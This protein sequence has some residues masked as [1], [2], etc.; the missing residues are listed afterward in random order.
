MP[1][2]IKVLSNVKKAKDRKGHIK[3]QQIVQENGRA[4]IDWVN[5]KSLWSFRHQTSVLKH[6][7]Q[8]KKGF[9]SKSY[10]HYCQMDNIHKYQGILL[11]AGQPGYLYP[12]WKPFSVSEVK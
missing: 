11:N 1:Q 6:C 7:C 9:G 12:D 4:N 8:R 3:W 10:D 5:Q 2:T